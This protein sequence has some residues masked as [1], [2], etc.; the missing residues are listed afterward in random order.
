M[1]FSKTFTAQD[2]RVATYIRITALRWDRIAKEASAS[3][4]GYITAL[5]ATSDP[6]KPILPNMVRFRLEGSKFDQ[7][8]SAATLAQSQDDVFAAIYEAAKS[9]P[10]KSDWGADPFAGALDT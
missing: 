2:G 10:C 8:L 5:K 7:Y 1:A 6:D 3:F 4:S 9:E